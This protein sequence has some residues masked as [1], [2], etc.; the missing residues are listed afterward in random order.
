MPLN[1]LLK[2]REYKDGLVDP[3]GWWMSEK[4]DG[5]RAYWDG[6]KMFS[7]TG[8]EIYAPPYFTKVLPNFPLDGE[9]WKGKGL[10]EETCTCVIR[11]KPVDEK[12]WT[13]LWKGVTYH[14]FDAPEYPGPF[15]A[16]I[17]YAKKLV[18]AHHPILRIIPMKKCESLEHLN[19]ELEAITLTH[20]E[21]IM[22]REPECLYKHGRSR[23]LLKVKPHR[24]DEVKM[25]GINREGKSL[26]CESRNGEKFLLP[27]SPYDFEHPPEIGSVITV[28]I[29]GH[30]KSGKPR[31][32][33]FLRVRTDVT[34][35]EILAE[36]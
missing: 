24:E 27:C 28:R 32:P 19:A 33:T 30:H 36:K 4:L 20:G 18:G 10:F 7:K 15:E 22:L 34:W 17:E 12:E 13:Y 5:V 9:L 11:R 21:G 3:T 25:I 1:F 2:A 29:A 6:Q 14:I 35:E 26:V 31:F 16:R 8:N 23:T